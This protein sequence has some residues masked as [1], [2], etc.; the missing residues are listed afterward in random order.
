V[1]AARLILPALRWHP[2]TRFA[3]EEAVI[4]ETLRLGVGG[5]I[6]FGSLG[7]VASEVRALTAEI[8]RLAKRPILIAADLERGAGQQALDLTEFPPPLAL[9][10]LGQ[11]EVIRWAGAMTAWEARSLGIDWVLGPD[12]DLDVE[13]E[14]PIIQTRS[15]GEDPAGVAE[16]V[17]TWIAGCQSG[18]ALTCAKHFPGHGR[19]RSDSHLGLPIVEAPADTLAQV[20]LRPFEAAVRAGTDAIMTAHVAY[21]ALDPTARPATFSSVILGRLRREIGFNGLVVTDALIM[22]GALEGHGEAE[23]SL[24]AIKAGCDLLL[25]PSQPDRVLR[26]LEAAL[27]SGALPAARLQESV[28]RYERALTPRP[29]PQERPSGP[30]GSVA[31]LADALLARGEVRGTAGT[32]G[33]ALSLDVVD[34]DLGGPFAPGPTDVVA[35]TLAGRGVVQG[36]AGRR[37]VLVFAEPRAAKGRAGLGE[38]SRARLAQLVP[39]AALVVVFGHPRIAAQVPGEVPILLAWHRQ[40]LMQE[41]VGRWLSSR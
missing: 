23:A 28:A 30:Y 1:T 25:Y 4:K 11:P 33:T 35:K 10:S 6:I 41:A 2:R 14:N 3:H 7:A 18:G 40:A 5:F 37:V 13:P 34:D 27:A 38:A 39:G 12:A 31:D 9:A 17:A 16:C 20:D 32:L 24:Q 8:R 19:T 22:E 29:W 26:A 21:P 15:F 36:M